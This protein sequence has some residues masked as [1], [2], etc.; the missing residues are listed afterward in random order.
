VKSHTQTS[1]GTTALNFTDDRFTAR[2]SSMAVP[3]SV[4]A[5]GT[6]V[7][8]STRTRTAMVAA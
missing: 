4:R 2:H 3:A 5:V 1:R 7:L 6:E 8:C